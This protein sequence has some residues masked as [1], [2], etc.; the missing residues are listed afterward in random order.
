MQLEL[1]LVRKGPES[2]RSG[3]HSTPKSMT[4]HYFWTFGIAGPTTGR[5]PPERRQTV[6]A[7]RSRQ[8]TEPGGIDDLSLS[9]NTDDQTLTEVVAPPMDR[10]LGRHCMQ[11]VAEV[12][13]LER[14]SLEHLLYRLT[15]LRALLTG[16]DEQFLSWAANEVESARNQVRETDL[17]RAA[18]VQ[19]LG[20]HG[21]N[22]TIP[23]L[24]QLA[25]L[26]REPWAGILRDHHD[27][28]TNMVAEIEVV[29]YGSAERAR[30]GIRRVADAQT[31]EE[32]RRG[33]LPAPSRQHVG[34]PVE[35]RPAA[36][37]PKLSTWMP[38]SFGDDLGPDD[39]DLTLL[40]TESA[41][42][43][44]LTASGKLQI[45]SLIAFLR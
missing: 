9:A 8:A 36:Q 12:L 4:S 42:Q 38:L 37:R 45:P 26:A 32:R 29:R 3:R 20:V 43:D 17:L 35:T 15:A 1:L 21:P 33:R 24:R 41:Y 30:Q 22:R 10:R 7:Q 16:R 23:T 14:N 18:Q 39:G 40:T 44:A 13:R 34:G 25:S 27:A 2:G 19:L 5:E 28:L 6:A 31:A 11:E